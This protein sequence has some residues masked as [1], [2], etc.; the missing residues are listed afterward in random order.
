MLQLQYRI[1]TIL[2]PAKVRTGGPEALHQLGRALIDL[3]H[4]ARIAYLH[5]DEVILST[6]DTS[7]VPLIDDPVPPEY[8]RYAVPRTLEISDKPGDA[9]LFPEIWP[10]VIRKF[11]NLMPYLWWLSIDNGLSAAAR[12]GGFSALGSAR[13]VHLSQSY[14]GL[15]YLAERDI[16]AMALFDYTSPDHF[17]A[18]SDLHIRENRILYPARGRW[19]TGYLRRWAPDL[20]WQEISGFTSAQVGELFR[21]SKLYVDFGKHPGKGRMPREAA[22]QGCCIITGKRGAASNPFD[23]PIPLRYK[24][25]DSRLRVPQ[26]IRAIRAT[27]AGYDSRVREFGIYQRMIEGERQE[28]TAQVARVFGGEVVPAPIARFAPAFENEERG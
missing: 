11:N 9:V 3:G 22:I 12:F 24:F 28:F 17:L 25:N 19:F 27:L 26:I 14:Y 7:T 16:S 15:Q 21:T 13:C 10:G 23:I 8:A 1:V 5:S 6:G 20:C 18:A 4:D 2:C